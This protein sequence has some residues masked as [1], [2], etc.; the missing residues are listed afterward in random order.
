MANNMKKFIPLLFICLPIIGF[1]LIGGPGPNDPIVIPP[2]T[3]RTGNPEA[4]FQ[5]IITGDYVNSGMPP[6]FYR[7]AFGKDGK[8]PLQREG[9]N[10][11][12]RYD[13]TAVQAANGK[14]IV[15][16]N[17]LQCHGQ[18][19]EDSLIV[20]LGNVNAD[21]TNTKG[22]NSKTANSILEQ[23]FTLNK[24]GGEAAKDFLQVAQTIGNKILV[25]VKG[26]NIA[27][28]LTAVLITHRDRNTL[29]WNDSA[30]SSLPD[31][32][33]PS[34]VPAWWLLKKKNAMFYNGFGRGDFGK[35]LMGAILLTV[36]DTIHANA[37]DSH[38][39]DVLAY[40]NAI[41][42][43][44]YPKQIDQQLAASGQIVFDNNCASCHGTYGRNP[45]YPNYLIPQ[46]VIGT[47]SMINNSN[48][49]HGDMVEW[50]NSSWFSKGDHPAKLVPFNGFIAPPLDGVWITAPYLHNGSIPT[51]E[52]L[53]NS[54]IRPTRWR[55]NFS[56]P[57]YD[58]VH[59]GWQFTEP[60]ISNSRETYDTT[61][62]G[63]GN[64]GHYYGDKLSPIERTA[65][66]EYLKTL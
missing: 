42:P 34:D 21:F 40:I 48:Y 13:F 17:C 44:K 10:A 27:D 30:T 19:F 24:A 23:Y 6:F 35:F 22:L 54:T 62:P 43:P 7:L 49:Q 32:V 47:D 5:Y 25:P 52:A 4:G 61:I 3:Q 14:T 46:R 56:K 12:I 60:A 45:S 9:L 26:V 31:E 53:L 36:N 55:R 51:I 2:S 29:A 39:N 65:V 63:Y 11:T 57:V 8:N 33:I 59:L 15:V 64:G 58:Y 16:P 66:L 38:M 28:R 37:V 41:Q 18:I 1:Q 50:F 20:G